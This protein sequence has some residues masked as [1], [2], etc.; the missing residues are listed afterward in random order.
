[1]QRAY[2]PEAIILRKF[3]LRLLKLSYDIYPHTF[4]LQ[5]FCLGNPMEYSSFK[6]DASS[7]TLST[8]RA[9][10]IYGGGIDGM[11]NR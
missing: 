1:M 8:G 3:P 7:I 6:Q 4:L 9:G 5:W 10:M 2:N 11:I